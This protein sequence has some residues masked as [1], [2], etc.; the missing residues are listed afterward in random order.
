MKKIIIIMLLCLSS[1]MAKSNT[2]STVKQMDRT[3]ED[4]HVRVVGGHTVPAGERTFQVALLKKGRAICGGSIVADQWVMTAAHCVDGTGIT[5]IL[6]NTQ[7]LNAGGDHH[8]IIQIIKHPDYNKYRV[9][10]GNDIALIRI[11]DHFNSDL[12]RLKIASDTISN[13]A[14]TG[15]VSGWGLT[16]STNSQLSNELMVV[17]QTIISDSKC[18]K[19]QG[20]SMNEESI[21][22]A[23]DED[24]SS[25]NG[26]SGGPLT[27]EV[28]TESYSIGIVSYGPQ[29]CSGYSAY[30][31][32]ANFTKWINQY[33]QTVA[34]TPDN[35]T[36]PP[37]NSC[38]KGYEHFKGTIDS[39]GFTVVRNK[40]YKANKGLHTYISNDNKVTLN[41][42]KHVRTFFFQY[43]W[44]KVKSSVSDLSYDGTSGNY[45]L[46]IKGKAGSKYDICANIP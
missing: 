46:A 36:T 40:S 14:K 39:D 42:Y 1:T 27:A 31:E 23:Y 7:K 12:E 30:T 22:C 25:C 17:T 8:K 33:I 24:V 3:H 15:D 5:E 9:S 11:N 4:Y 6:S 38:P 45:A 43:N 44:K 2:G 32:T 41:L 35:N 16:K 10:K 37:T 19:L 28:N 34:E 18:E 26:D 29:S 21:I 20:G 13:Q